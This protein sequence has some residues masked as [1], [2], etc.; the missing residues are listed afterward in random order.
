MYVFRSSTGTRQPIDY[1]ALTYNYGTKKWGWVAH[2]KPKKSDLT[3]DLDSLGTEPAAGN[4]DLYFAS[5]DQVLVSI[6]CFK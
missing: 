6:T 3:Y 5:A 2:F 4:P 1:H